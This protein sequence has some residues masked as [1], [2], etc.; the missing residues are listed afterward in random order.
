MRHETHLDEVVRWRELSLVFAREEDHVVRGDSHEILVRYE[1]ISDQHPV[2]Q[3]N[4]IVQNLL[5]IV[6]E[7]PE[8]RVQEVDEHLRAASTQ[9]EL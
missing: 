5:L 7:P 4:E 6:N 3:Q 8:E 2:V 9:S 1:G